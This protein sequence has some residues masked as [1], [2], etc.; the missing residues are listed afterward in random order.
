[1]FK[2]EQS[3]DVEVAVLEREEASIEQLDR[4]V[5]GLARRRGVSELR[6]LVG[7]INRR[8]GEPDPNLAG[9]MTLLSRRPRQELERVQIQIERLA[10][11][12]RSPEI[13]RLAFAAWVA[14]AGADDAFLTASQSRDSLRD[15][16]AAVPYVDVRLR[17]ELVKVAPL[18]SNCRRCGVMRPPRL[19]A[20]RGDSRRI[21]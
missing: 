19:T 1:M 18:F 4:A 8:L 14:A 6:L 10:L 9:F 3:E 17:G 11:S 12:G 15:F 7:L 13:R 20:G 21:L 5:S 16:L 2:F